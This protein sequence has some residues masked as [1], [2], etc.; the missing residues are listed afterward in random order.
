MA[1]HPRGLYTLF[2]TEMWERLGYYGMRALLVLFM[3]AAVAD[4]G[5]GLDDKTAAAIYGLFTCAVYLAALPGGW[6]ADRLLGARHAVTVGG[7]IIALGYFA[8]AIPRRETFYLGLILVVLGTGLLKPNISAMVGQLYANDPARRDAGFTLFYMGINLGAMLGPLVCSYLGERVHW[9]LGFAA[10]GAG[11][12]LGLLQFQLTRGAL[13]SAGSAPSISRARRARDGW[14]VAGAVSCIAGVYLAGINGWLRV[15]AGTLARYTAFSIVGIGA[16]YFVFLFTLG[17]LTTAERK[18]LAVIG[19]LFAASAVF[20]AG[21]EQAGSSLNLFGERFTDRTI[22]DGFV[23]PAGWLQTFSPI[24]V[25]GFAPLVAA[26]WVFMARR[27]RDV[28]VAVK[29]SLALLFLAAGFLVM[30]GASSAASSGNKVAP[31]WLITTYLLH[32]IGELC[33]SPVGLSSVTSLAPARLV[34]QMM[35]LWFMATS[36]GN[37]MAGLAAGRVTAGSPAEMP[38]MFLLMAAGGILA[39]GM[40]LCLTWPIRVLAKS[41]PS[42]HS[43]ATSSPVP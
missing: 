43:S 18:R 2:F 37:L 1:V 29:F 6:V 36:F 38:T 4:G 3:G 28:P 21:F 25:I 41:S 8:L 10:A 12:L 31:T 27:G 13:G 35:G 9:R 17:G 19:L 30:A 26:G 16:G 5:L 15:P 39:A 14:L 22:W 40:M 34:G 11:M 20:W 33:I 42:T 32:S 23:V 7:C 24:F